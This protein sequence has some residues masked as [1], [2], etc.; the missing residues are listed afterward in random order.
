MK[1]FLDRQYLEEFDFFDTLEV[2]I[3]SLIEI[4]DEYELKIICPK[5]DKEELYKIEEVNKDISNLPKVIVSFIQDNSL[6]ENLFYLRI[7]RTSISGKKLIFDHID[8][9]Y[10]WYLDL[11]DEEFAMFKGKI[12]VH[13][14]PSGLFFKEDEMVRIK[15]KGLLGHLGFIKDYTPNQYQI[16]RYGK[17]NRKR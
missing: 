8:D 5:N 7:Y 10:S 11:T 2:A 9:T 17:I 16:Q 4:N 12:I 15:A 6:I 1:Y 13:N 14:L 3:S